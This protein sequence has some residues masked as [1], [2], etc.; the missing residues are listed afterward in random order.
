MNRLLGVDVSAYQP[1]NLPWPLWY[2]AGVRFAY[3]R[4]GLGYVGDHGYEKHRENARA[5]RMLTGAYFAILDHDAETPQFD[6]VQSAR[7]FDRLIIPGDELPPMVDVEALGVDAPLLSAFLREFDRLRP[8]SGVGIYTSRYFWQMLIGPGHYEFASRP[9]WVAMYGINGQQDPPRL[10]DIWSDYVGYQFRYKAGYLPGYANDLDIDLWDWES[11]MPTLEEQLK[12][13]IAEAGSAEEDCNVGIAA[14]QAAKGKLAD[15]RV[16]LAGLIPAPPPPPPPP[17]PPWWETKIPPYNLPPQN[18]TITFYHA[19]GTP[20][21]PAITRNVT[22]AMTVTAR[23]GAMLLVL[24]QTG[25]A[26]D[27][28]VKAGD[29]NVPA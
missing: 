13:L 1:P 3:L 8:N 2:G 7:A 28:W 27:W 22:W 4:A 9:L 25:T 20:F 11:I 19:D 26:N 5:A 15:M 12:A 16:K 21:V 18:K 6:P 17:P 14:S 23:S 10:P 24:D 29:L